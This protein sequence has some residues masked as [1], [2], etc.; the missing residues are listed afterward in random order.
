MADPIGVVKNARLYPEIIPFA[1][2]NNIAAGSELAAPIGLITRIQQE[3]GEAKWLRMRDLR[4][5]QTAGVQVR[6]RAD[7][8]SFVLDTPALQALASVVPTNMDYLATDFWE[9]T[10][11]NSTAGLV[12]AQGVS[13]GLAILQASVADKIMA[14]QG[15]PPEAFLLPEEIALA[16]KRS[17][18]D[19]VAKGTLP[20]PLNF[21]LDRYY[22]SLG[23]R[24]VHAITVPVVTPGIRTTVLKR[25]P[26]SNEVLVLVGIA[27]DTDA[28]AANVTR[29]WI[30]RDNTR[31]Y[32]DLRTWAMNI[33]ADIPCWL[34]ALTDL[35]VEITTAAGAPLVNYNVRLTIARIPISNW[36]RMQW[37]LITA[38]SNP[39]LAEVVQGGIA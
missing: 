37:G 19:A 38:A 24:E 5:T 26:R 31:N 18:F 36:M 28:L 2:V 17:L 14:N 34:P 3:V 4:V 16:K 29:L 39:D 12:T 20:S 33:A 21:R 9:F 7:S 25:I 27:A 6:V 32:N 8:L 15:R 35:T 30:S 10:E 1:E 13:F 11:V 22:P 23:T